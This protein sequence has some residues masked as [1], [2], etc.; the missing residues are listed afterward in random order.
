MRQIKITGYIPTDNIWEK[1][2][3][4][5]SI[6]H[7]SFLKY[8][9]A[10]F[11]IAWEDLEAECHKARIYSEQAK[12]EIRNFC[13][14]KGLSLDEDTLST[15]F[16]IFEIKGKGMYMVPA[17]EAFWVFQF[18]ANTSLKVLIDSDLECMSD[19]D[20]FFSE[21]PAIRDVAIIYKLN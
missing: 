12:N 1:V 3:A 15:D 20:R 21:G 2:Q 10:E 18:E 4:V 16:F 11:G 14:E 17:H 5:H 13:K 19:E 9:A 6:N 8:F 7:L